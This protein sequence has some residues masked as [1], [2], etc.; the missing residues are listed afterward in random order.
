MNESQIKGGHA[1]VADAP[2]RWR[3]TAD[4]YQC[5]GQAG[6]LRKEDH[7][8]LIGGELYEMTPI[9]SWHNG[10]VNALAAAFFNGLGGRA[11]VQV[12]GS[13]RLSPDSEPEPD[14]LLLRFRSDFY[15]A[16]LPGPQDVLLLVE[17]ADTSL[18]YDRDFKLPIYASA[19]IPEVWIVSRDGP[20]I[21]FY[22]EPR[23]GRYQVKSV[24][25]RGSVIAPLAF[26]DLA[27]QVQEIL[28]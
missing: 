23:D 11:I 2:R 1:G 28:G 25:E 6:I 26:P 24:S 7:V 8:E 21:E 20:G 16:A 10:S 5:M 12:Q 18:G 17:I 13:F 15:R 4:Q 22:R 19:G 27:V 9:G 14:I 3:F